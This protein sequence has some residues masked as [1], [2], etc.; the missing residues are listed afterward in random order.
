MIVPNKTDATRKEKCA[1]NGDIPLFC[2]AGCVTKE[3]QQAENHTCVQNPRARNPERD[4]QTSALVFCPLCCHDCPRIQNIQ[5]T[6]HSH[7]CFGP[8]QPKRYRGTTE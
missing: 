8:N 3:R 6:V 5:L 4:K 7:G 1:D 2:G